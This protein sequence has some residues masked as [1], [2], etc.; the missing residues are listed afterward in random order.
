MK[1]W[2]FNKKVNMVCAGIA[3]VCAIGVYAIELVK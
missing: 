3:L 2:S 1:K